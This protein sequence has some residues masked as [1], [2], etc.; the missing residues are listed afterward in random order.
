MLL[1]LPTK[2]AKIGEVGYA[3]LQGYRRWKP[4]TRCAVSRKL[5]NRAHCLCWKS[6][7]M[8]EMYMLYRDVRP[9]RCNKDGD[10][11]S[12]Y[13]SVIRGFAHTWA[14]SVSVTIQLVA[15]SVRQNRLPV[16]ASARTARLLTSVRCGSTSATM[17]TCHRIEMHRGRR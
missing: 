8:S 1:W 13:K 16:G 17:L 12:C 15:A 3:V 5:S 14:G 9:Q 6:H 2:L 4:C 10:L 7:E 11:Q